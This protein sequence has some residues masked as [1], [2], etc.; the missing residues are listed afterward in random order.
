[1]LNVVF[2]M[3]LPS[4]I[5]GE[6]SDVHE[7]VAFG[8]V[9]AVG[10]AIIAFVLYFTTSFRKRGVVQHY[11]TW[12]LAGVVAAIVLVFPGGLSEGWPSA[13]TF[14][15]W[16]GVSVGLGLGAFARG[17]EQRTARE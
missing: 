13:L 2:R 9:S 7:E 12:I 4:L 8:A 10:G 15:L 11:L 14:A 16:A 1:M 6:P 3:V 5:S 17:V